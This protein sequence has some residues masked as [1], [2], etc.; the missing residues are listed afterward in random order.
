MCPDFPRMHT[1]INHNINTTSFYTSCPLI[2]LTYCVEVHTSCTIADCSPLNC[3]SAYYSI[4]SLGS[5]VVRTPQ[6]R[7]PQ[8][9]C[10]LG[11]VLLV[12]VYETLCPL[13]V[14][15]SIRHSYLQLLRLVDKV[16]SETEALNLLLVLVII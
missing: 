2:R 9:R 11:G 15:H 4:L 16:K 5:S 6:D 8:S 13:T 12:R 14:L 10:C 7:P 1:L 3:F